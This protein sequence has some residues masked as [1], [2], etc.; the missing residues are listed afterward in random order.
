MR[1][2]VAVMVLLLAVPLPFAHAHTEVASTSPTAGE[3]LDQ[4]PTQ[5][6]VTT[7]EPV[8]EMGSAIVVT[9]PSGGRVDDGSTEIDGTVTLV[10]LVALTEF[11]EYTVNYRLLA[12]DGHPIEGSFTFSLV[13]GATTQSPSPEPTDTPTETPTDSPTQEPAGDNG[14]SFPWWI[15]AAVVA[16]ASGIA[17]AIRRR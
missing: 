3:R 14:G 9:S 10:G 6:T 16:A 8:Q 11:G 4:A 5:V 2:L 1:R 12:S 17:L 13:E 7:V 15:I